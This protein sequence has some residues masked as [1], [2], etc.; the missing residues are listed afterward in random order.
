[1][2]KRVEKGHDD[3]QKVFET[4]L[5]LSLGSGSSLTQIGLVRT[6]NRHPKLLKTMSANAPLTSNALISIEALHAIYLGTSTVE[7]TYSIQH[8]SLLFCCDIRNLE[9]GVSVDGASHTTLLRTGRSR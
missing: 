6:V 5:R 9:L 1:M 8:A 2:A 3:S 7:N 4:L